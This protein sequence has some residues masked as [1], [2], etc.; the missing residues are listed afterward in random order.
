MSTTDVGAD[1]VKTYTLD[2][3]A[4]GERD[5]LRLVEH[6][7]DPGSRA[8]FERIGVSEGWNAL[9]VAGGG[10]SL[11][12][13][14]ARRVGPSGSVLATDLDPRFLRALSADYDNLEVRQHNVVTE[15]LPQARYDIVHTRL[16]LA[17]LPERAEVIAKMAAAVKPGGYLVLEDFDAGSFGP[18]Y[19]SEAAVK[20]RDAA[21]AYLV[22]NGYEPYTGRRL[23]GWMRA[24]GLVE[25]DA[26]GSVLTLR[27]SSPTVA[28]MYLGTVLAQKQSMIDHGLISEEDAVS[29][30][31]RYADPEYDGLA[32][33]MVTAWGRR[34][35]R[36]DAHAAD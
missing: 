2:N 3:A 28:P 15:P 23:A 4:K 12:E 11:V 21:S 36:D 33:T 1:Y 5:R 25:V 27:G 32:H 31:S 18:A 26:H 6:A 8:H 17:W 19:T 14:M 22:A 10:G 29:L 16:L 20:I 13:W 9:M 35:V 34:T 24:A 7:W 30:E